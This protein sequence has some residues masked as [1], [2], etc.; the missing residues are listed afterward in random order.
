MRAIGYFLIRAGRPDTP[1]DFGQDLEDFCYENNH[2]LVCVFSDSAESGHVER[3]GY[4]AMIEFMRSSGSEFLTVVPDAAHLAPDLESVGRAMVALEG[5]GARVACADVDLP[6]PLQNAFR[7]FG[8][9]GVSR[10]RSASVRESMRTRA[11]NGQALGRPPYGYRVGSGGALEVVKDEAVVV[12]LMYRL[13]SKDGL[14]L[15]LIVQHLNER[16][17]STR[18]N[19]RWNMTTVRDILKNSAYIGTYA[20]FGMIVPRV[21][22]PIIPR[23]VF[24]AAQDQ[25]AARR[26]SGR[27]MSAE[28]FLLSGLAYCGYC[29]NKMMGVTRRQS[30]RLKD[31]R[32][33]SQVYRYYQCQS[34]NNQS[35]CKYHTWRA[36]LLEATVLSQ[37]TLVAEAR[38]ARG[39][40]DAA[41]ASDR[42]AAVLKAREDRVRNAERRFLGAMRRAAMGEITLKVVGEYLKEL[43]ATRQALSTAKSVTESPGTLDRWDSLGMLERQAL[44]EEQVSRIVVMDDSVELVD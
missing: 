32:R 33:A 6:D 40:A 37:L 28:P 14:G 41:R 19:G 20:R 35:I 23:D 25:T 3:P 27:V 1:V 31:R 39:D 42:R 4:Q 5:M 16:G 44:L 10:T 12:E 8:V 43:D 2:Q 22:E 24:R 7:I 29:G 36:P 30:W 13:Y 18:R 21:H 11:L 15:R 17:I 9:K 34:R 26:P 38:A